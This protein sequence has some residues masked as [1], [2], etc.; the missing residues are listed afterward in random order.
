MTHFSITIQTH[1]YR[2]RGLLYV[3]GFQDALKIITKKG[4]QEKKQVFC[5]ESVKTKLGCVIRY[6]RG[7]KHRMTKCI[8][9]PKVTNSSNKDLGQVLNL[10]Q[11]NSKETSWTG[12][13]FRTL[14]QH[15]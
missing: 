15:P 1:L 3:K 14:T 13:L 11:L 10:A 4:A 7:Q 9:K 12:Q 6:I 2:R 8:R 5:W